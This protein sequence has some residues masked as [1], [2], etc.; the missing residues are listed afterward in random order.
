MS[1]ELLY[2][3]ELPEKFIYIKNE[4]Y[5]DVPWLFNIIRTKP[6]SSIFAEYKLN[7]LPIITP[8]VDLKVGAAQQT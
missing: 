2:N 4:E 1:M 8:P 6:L 7:G 3:N 5:Y